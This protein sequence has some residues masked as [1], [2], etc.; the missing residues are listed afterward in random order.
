MSVGLGFAGVGLLG[1]SML[2]QLD[3]VP[4]L[5]LAAVQDVN[6]DLVTQVAE[7]CASPWYGERFEDLISLPDVDAVVISTPNVLHVPQAQAALRAGKHVL[8][9]KPLAT[10]AADARATVDIASALGL[11]LFVDYSYRMLDTA[12]ALR[13]AL[14]EIGAVGAVSAVFHNIHGPRRGREW[15]TNPSLSGGGALIDLGVHMLDLALWVLGPREARLERADLERRPGLDVEHSASAEL[16]FDNIPVTLEVSWDSPRPLTEIS[17][18]LDGARGQSCW[19]NVG[20]SFAHFR[21]RVDQKLLIDKEITLRENTLR[22]FAA[23]LERG[24]A[25]PI[26]SRVYDLLDQAYGRG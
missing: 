9:Q 10:S 14:P 1:Q 22:R 24:S 2:E 25:P 21:T 7:R 23:A 4:G 18:T 20:G 3:K 11:V 16:R 26:D 6:L 17:L 13:T 8:V 19:E 15:F 5:R 12:V